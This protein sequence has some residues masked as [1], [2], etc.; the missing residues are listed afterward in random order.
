MRGGH[1]SV[2]AE[3]TVAKSTIP[4]YRGDR[5]SFP[6]VTVLRPNDLQL[7]NVLA[8]AATGGGP[9][10]IDLFSGAG[11]LSLGLQQ[12]GFQIV[13]AVDD[14]PA[15]AETHAKAIGGCAILADLT[16]PETLV[17]AVL[18]SNVPISLVAG[19]PPC[20]PFSRAA[21]SKIRSLR[22]E[23]HKSDSR[24]AL[25][26]SFLAFVDALRPDAVL[27]ENVPD[28]TLWD[29]GTVLRAICENLER[30]SYAVHTRVL[31]CWQYGVPQHR[32]RLFV[33]AHR[34]ERAFSWPT[35]SRSTVTLREAIS[36]MPDVEGGSREYWIPLSE[37]VTSAF[38]ER[39]RVKGAKH[40]SDHITRA[41]R[42]DD[43]QVFELMRDGARYSDVP[44]ELRRYRADIFDD[45][46]N[47]L[48][49]DGLSRSITAHIAKDGY[50][51]I[52]PNGRRTL[53]IRE[54]ARLQTFP[55]WFRFA[56]YPSDRLRQIGNAV[57]PFVAAAI[58][59]ELRRCLEGTV[60]QT[61][62]SQF[63]KKA[64]SRRVLRWHVRND[65]RYPWRLTNDPWLIL[66]TEI[67]LRRTRAD[68]VAG[69]WEKFAGSFPTPRSVV[70]K[71]Q[72]LRSLLEP[73]GL[74]WRVDN[75]VELA[76]DLDSRGGVV[77][78][79]KRSLMEL[80]GVGDYVA[81]AV[82]AFAFGERVALVDT[83]TARIT[84][85][86]FG[87]EENPTSLRN[88]NLRAGVARLVG[89]KASPK[90]NLAL[91]DLGRLV[92]KPISPLCERC[93]IAAMCQYRSATPSQ[94]LL[95]D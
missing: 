33:I 62:G 68:A 85:R 5:V 18:D 11:G 77:P 17:S 65:R 73:L 87:L 35:S 24:L 56:G 95:P 67:L 49:W 46:Y 94:T 66:A 69:V 79:D 58:G 12:A 51:Y 9:F 83:N 41:V 81:D 63:E 40:I 57:P 72:R 76:R 75:L 47:V 32:Q 91:I 39:M 60:N 37:Q 55:D 4:F 31:S 14:N 8:S 10:A 26:R 45:K 38:Q 25:W 52:H 82:L 64:F 22:P 74:R 28:L 23:S 53:S 21:K 44:E 6:E 15:A 7:P 42:E 59:V 70:R 71:E 36:D 34:R 80:P 13:M 20:Q 43:R 93:P 16:E 78:H 92:C 48:P 89:G 90:L 86:M 30:R 50:W 54:A 1:L 29:H 3:L 27:L 88:L 2:E 19:S 84:T 61:A